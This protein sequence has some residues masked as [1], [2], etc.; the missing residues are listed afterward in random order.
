MDS[1]CPP[2]YTTRG[3]AGPGDH[4][5]MAVALS[6]FH[7]HDGDG[8]VVT[9]EQIDVTYSN[10]PLTDLE[11]DVIIVEHVTDGVVGYGRTGWDDTPEGR[12]QFWVAPL[13][14]SHLAEPLLIALVSRLERRA[15]ERAALEPAK[16]HVFR[17][18]IPHAGPDQP[19]GDTPA[20][21]LHNIGYRA[22]RFGASMVRPH[23]NDILELPL[24]DGVDLRPV[25]TGQLRAIWEADVAAF[26]GEFGSQEPTTEQWLDFRDNPIADPTLWKVAWSG[27]RI[28]GQVRSY[29]N[30]QENESQHRLRGYTEFI[31]THAEWRGRGLAS[32][33]LAISLREVRDRG[34][35]EAALGVDTENPANA[36]GIYQRLGFALTGYEAVMDKPIPLPPVKPAG[37]GGPARS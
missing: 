25:D 28:V 29:I 4:A 17:C 10:I 3:Y 13:R 19:L 6:E 34:M 7:L 26:A 22:V 5:A 14:T 33:L 35:A 11:H 9:T 12:T 30:E 32:S 18:W 20:G 31:S 21:W 15:T 36:L 23:L 37:N 8:E 24:P 1:D 2:G 27:D 16:H